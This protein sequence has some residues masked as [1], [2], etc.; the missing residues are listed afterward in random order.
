MRNP[1]TEEYQ[2]N[3]VSQISGKILCMR[4]RLKLGVLS[5]ARERRVW[6]Y[7][8]SCWS[9][10]RLCWV[11]LKKS[12]MIIMHKIIM[13]IMIIIHCI[14]EAV[15]IKGTA[16]RV[17]CM[18]THS[19]DFPCMYPGIHH[20]HI[21]NIHV[22]VLTCKLQNGMQLLN[23][24]KRSLLLSWKQCQSSGLPLDNGSILRAL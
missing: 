4:K 13:I 14:L 17:Y 24:C 19:R 22:I 5:S 7:S 23:T 21:Y 11:I 3:T 20:S 9:V 16:T 1:Y 6:G 15:H 10:L 18:Y 12:K 2:N 8:C